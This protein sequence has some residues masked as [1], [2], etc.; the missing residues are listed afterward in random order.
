MNTTYAFMENWRKLS[1]NYHQMGRIKRIW[2]L[3]PMWAAKVQAN[4]CCSLKQAGSQEK[5]SDRKPF[6][7]PLWTA[8]HAQLKFVMTEC[9]KTQIHLT[10]HK[11]PLVLSAPRCRSIHDLKNL[12]TKYELP[13]VKTN[14]VAVCPAKTQ[15]RLTKVSAIRMKKA[16]VLSY[17]LSAQ[18]RLWS[19]WADAQAD[20][21]L[22]WAHSHFVGFIMRWLIWTL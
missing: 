16:W 2:Y 9:S 4:L 8:G 15:I 13:H 10:R 17:P 11:H 19:V 21:S 6:P 7:W 20:L 1:L 5:P 3:S 14:K 12:C 18:R 22:L